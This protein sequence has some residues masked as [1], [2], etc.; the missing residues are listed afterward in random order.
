[1]AKKIYAGVI[2]YSFDHEGRLVYLLGREKPSKKSYINNKWSDFGGSPEPTDTSD[3]DSASREAYEESMGF[4]GTQNEIKRLIEINKSYVFRNRGIVVFVVHI[5]YDSTLP[6]H[7]ADVYTYIRK[8]ITNFKTCRRTGY[9][10]KTAIAW[11]T[12]NDILDYPEDYRS[13]F[14]KTFKRIAKTHPI[15][16]RED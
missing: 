4:L 3:E 9:F 16:S 12:K 15:L 6:R 11:V 5:P 14:V 13:C 7:Y 8:G 1:M 10:E 2:P